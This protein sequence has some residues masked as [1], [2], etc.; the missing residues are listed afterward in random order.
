[1][2]VKILETMTPTDVDSKAK[3][4]MVP[5]RDGCKLGTDVYVPVSNDTK[6]Y[7][8]VLVRTPYDKSSRYTAMNVEAEYFM[9]RGYVFVGQDVRGKY[10]STGETIPYTHDVD[11]AYDTVE[12]IIKQPWSN[13]RV[14][15]SGASYY[16]FTAWATVACG[17]PAVKA[18]AP[19]VT[20]I[21]MAQC[22]VSSI[23]HRDVPALFALKDLFQIWSNNNGYLIDFDWSRPV[24]ELLAEMESQI[25]PCLAARE[26]LA[27]S[28]EAH[29]WNPYGKRHPYHTTDI[30]ILHCQ[31]WFDPGLAPFGLR[32]WRHFREVSSKRNLHY[33]RVASADHSGFLLSDA[34]AGF[35]RSPYVNSEVL[36]QRIE[37]DCGAQADFF[38][39][40]V[41]GIEPPTS[42]PHAQWHIGHLGW[43]ETPEF[44][45]PT[46]PETFY[47]STAQQSSDPTLSRK[48]PSDQT[49]S[50]WVHNPDK[51]V[52]STTDIESIWYLLTN[53]PD[54][55]DMAERQ[56]VLTFTTESL[57]DDLVF[58]GRPQFVARIKY[59]SQTAHLFAKLQ[60]VYPDGTTRPISW[61]AVVLDQRTGPDVR[62]LLDDNAYCIR[63]GHR[64]QLQVQSSNWPH[65]AIHPGTEE[66]PWFA[67]KRVEVKNSIQ[68]GGVYGARLIMPMYAINQTNPRL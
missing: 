31:S 2:S 16:G 18:A 47:L 64:L 44:P 56:D 66:N 36:Q 17:H 38:D 49:T 4:Y 46:Q 25:G 40:H 30:P 42:R 51:P 26:L 37:S 61:S 68:I 24:P 20:G 54:E 39:E 13:G 34:G 7:S 29:W 28:K 10:R 23:W 60:D 58:A 3:Q 14:A 59:E 1:M 32:D 45:P 53:Y 19:S 27:N 5:T 15:A 67:T 43:Q 48:L 9:S 22:H 41:N 12:W 6:T 63:A 52:P 55:R 35:D 33:L 11:D 65:F 57:K 8:A 62:I 21:E 50:H